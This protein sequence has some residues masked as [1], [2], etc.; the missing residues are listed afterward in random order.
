MGLLDSIKGLFGGASDKAA[1]AAGKAAAAATD[2]AAKAKD[3]VSGVAGAAAGATAGAEGTAKDA[4][5]SG[6]VNDKTGG[7]AEP[8]T[9]KVEEVGG[10]LVR[11]RKSRA[12]I[13]AAARPTIGSLACARG[14]DYRS[15]PTVL[16]STVSRHCSPP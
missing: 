5:A 8:V 2:T 12:R 1:D 7:K 10:R 13:L 3:S 11:G 9:S 6:F 16:R 14:R 4:A 15:C